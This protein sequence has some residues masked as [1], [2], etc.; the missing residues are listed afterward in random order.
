MD[1]NA[2][3]TAAGLALGMALIL[4]GTML[5][6]AGWIGSGQAGVYPNTQHISTIPTPSRS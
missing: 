6:T 4:A 1:G 5:I 3:K 2:M